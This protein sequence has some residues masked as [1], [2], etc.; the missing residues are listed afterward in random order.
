MKFWGN[1]IGCKTYVLNWCNI[2]LHTIS[3]IYVDYVD[4][5]CDCG[6]V[7]IRWC[8]HF[9]PILLEVY[10]KRWWR[11]AHFS[12]VE[13]TMRKHWVYFVKCQQS[14]SIGSIR[15][16]KPGKLINMWVLRWGWILFMKS[17]CLGPIFG[18]WRMTECEENRVE[19]GDSC[20]KVW[21]LS[22]G[23]IPKVIRC[24]FSYSNY[25]NVY[26]SFFCLSTLWCPGVFSLEEGISWMIIPT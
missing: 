18:W 20:T 12:W 26:T 17:Y 3:Y 21:P 11:R 7:K 9:L 16:S 15:R 4:M 14:S 5:N 22:V 23:M 24:F 19:K 1:A 2:N 10:R 13:V 6:F 8:N 25:M